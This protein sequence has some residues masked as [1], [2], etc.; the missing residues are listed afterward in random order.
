MLSNEADV[1]DD[2]VDAGEMFAGETDA[3]IHHQ[4]FAADGVEVQVHADFIRAAERYEEEFVVVFR[5]IEGHY[6]YQI[7]S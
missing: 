6:I 7:R 1:G 2:N 5:E 4:P 3:A